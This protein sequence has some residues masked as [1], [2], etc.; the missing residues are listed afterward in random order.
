MADL[1]PGHQSND[2]FEGADGAEISQSTVS[3]WMQRIHRS[4][5]RQQV[6]VPLDQIIATKHEKDCAG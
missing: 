4:A 1:E 2:E 6:E 5:L 3:R